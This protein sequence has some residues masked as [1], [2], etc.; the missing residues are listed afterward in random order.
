LKLLLSNDDGVHARGLKALAQAL[1]EIAAIK[2]VAPDR[3]YSGASHSLTLTRPLSLLTT[4]EGFLAVDGTP[5]DSVHLGLSRLIGFEPERVIAGINSHANLGDDVLYSGTVAAAMEGRFLDLPAIAVS[6]VNNG[7]NHFETA[8]TVV[9]KMLAD[10]SLPRLTQRTVLNINVPDVPYAQVR[11]VQ[12]T[13]LGH[14]FK[15]GEPMKIQDPRGRIR[16]WI[17]SAGEVD[18]AGEGTDFYAVKHG[19]VSITPINVDMTQ[20]QDVI[21]LQQWLGDSN[22]L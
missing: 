20:Q 12:I 4:S 9:K 22:G 2:V 19:F 7:S 3:D 5:T 17:A 1:A 6:L 13:R 10:E 11:G 15:G 21:S 18:D 8:A 14:R 16:Y